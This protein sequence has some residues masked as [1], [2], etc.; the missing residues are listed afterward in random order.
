VVTNTL[1]NGTNRFNDPHWTNHPQR[2]Y[3]VRTP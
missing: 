2:F 1:V 3:R